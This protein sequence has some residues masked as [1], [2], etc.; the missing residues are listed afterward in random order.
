M[1]ILVALFPSPR[2]EKRYRLILA[3]PKQVIDFGMKHSH[4]YVDGA[5]DL[6]RYNY[7][8]RHGKEDWT[9]L[10]A[11]SASRYILWGASHDI[12]KNLLDFIHKFGIYVPPGAKVVIG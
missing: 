5:S 3:N 8:K 9:K 2:K 7:L 6:T 4:T 11:G 10:S 12:H 1:P